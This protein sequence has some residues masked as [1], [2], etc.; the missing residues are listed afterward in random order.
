[1]SCREALLASEEIDDKVKSELIILSFNLART[2]EK[3]EKFGEADRI[4]KGILNR[5]PTYSDGNPL[6]SKNFY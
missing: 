3:L 2:D 6:F 1:M 4:Y 5:R